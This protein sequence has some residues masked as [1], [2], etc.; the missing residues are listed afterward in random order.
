MR[1]WTELAEI[2]FTSYQPD[3]R[4]RYVRAFV[5]TVAVRKSPP[6]HSVQGRGSLE[7]RTQQAGTV[8]KT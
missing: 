1:N 4:L 6:C 5:T 3:I 7:V 2:A 8:D